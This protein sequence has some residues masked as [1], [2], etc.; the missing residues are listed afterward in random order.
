MTTFTHRPFSGSTSDQ[1]AIL[2]WLGEI[3]LHPNYR[4][5]FHP[6]D[7]AWNYQDGLHTSTVDDLSLWFDQQDRMQAIGWL[8]SPTEVSFTLHPALLNTSDGETLIGQIVEWARD[9]SIN[10]DQPLE[11]PLD[12]TF[13]HSDPWL[14]SVATR[15]GFI[16]QHEPLYI[17][18]RQSLDRTLPEPVLPPGFAV[19]AMTDD[20]DIP[21]RVAI[22][23]DVWQSKKRT[24][25]RYLTLRQ[26]CLYRADLDL[27]VTAPDGTFA[28]YCLVW[29]DPVSSAAL[30]EPVGA[31]ETFRR[32]GLTAGLLTTA[33]HRLQAI[34]A[35]TAFVGSRATNEASNRLYESVGFERVQDWR[36]W[37]RP[38][39]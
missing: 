19:R 17:G 5:E 23:Q 30:F 18:F 4:M 15:L 3:I 9:R 26:G 35:T 24:L 37:R 22:H 1:N 21:A 2:R 16:D 28:S 27:V 36:L 7:F 25:E 10:L 31:R 33:L 39:N 13:D 34:G 6:G 38:G 8:D 29:F 14:R 12:L 11:S 32:R 20:A